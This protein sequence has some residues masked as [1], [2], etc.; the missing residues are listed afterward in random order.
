MGYSSSYSEI[1]RFEKNAAEYTTPNMLG[2][3]LDVAN[4][5]LIFAA[6]NVDHNIL[7]I[8]GKGTFHGMGMIAALTL[9]QRNVHSIPR[10]K[11]QKLSIAENVK[12][13]ILEHRLAKHSCESIKFAALP[14]LEYCNKT[15]DL[16]WELS[17]NFKEDVPSWQGLMYIIYQEK[18]HPGQ[19]SNRY[20]PMIDMYSGDKT[21]I[22]STLELICDLASKHNLALLSHSTIHYIGKHRR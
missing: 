16:L 19:S 2:N 4:T 8:D 12:V 17:F 10:N 21:C 20:L 3:N 14:I 15:V 1:Q 13:P 9:G 18:I 5:A 6:D 11:T 22:L 7:T